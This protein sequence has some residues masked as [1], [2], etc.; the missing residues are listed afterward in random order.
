MPRHPL[1]PPLQSTFENVYLAVARQPNRRTPELVTTGGG[2]FVAEAKETTDGRRFVFLPHSNRIYEEDW[3]F[4]ANKMGKDGQRIG[5]YAV[6][7]DKWARSLVIEETHSYKH[8]QIMTSAPATTL[9]PTDL[10]AQAKTTMIID[11]AIDFAAMTRVLVKGSNTIIADKL[12]Q[13]FAELDHVKS[14]QRYDEMHSTFCQ[15]FTEIIATAEKKK[16]DGTVIKRVGPSSWGQAAKVLDIT[17]KVFI[18]YSGLPSPDQ[19]QAL[20]PMLHGAIDTQILKHLKKRFRESGVRA[21]TI[22]EIDR[23]EYELLQSLV[24]KHIEEDFKSEICRVQYDDIF[25]LKLNRKG[26][27]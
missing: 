16:K 24:L 22:E 17:A 19:A 1:S 14:Q 23:A 21:T 2:R 13:L 10:A 9:N 3:G 25:F 26:T 15:W 6:P 11:M 8:S 20:V 12:A 18:Y 5:Q 27:P 7:L 4:T